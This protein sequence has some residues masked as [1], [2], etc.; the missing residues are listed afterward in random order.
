VLNSGQANSL[1]VKLNLEG[2]NGDIA[3]VQSFLAQ[4]QDFLDAGILTQ[5]QA[6]ALLEP[7]NTL[8]LSVTR[9]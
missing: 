2:N 4:V 8:L 7:G 9:R 5:R 6:S 3:K 1:I